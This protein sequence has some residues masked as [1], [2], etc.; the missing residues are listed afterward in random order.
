MSKLKILV[1][2]KAIVDLT[3]TPSFMVLS[4]RDLSYPIHFQ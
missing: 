4:I 2:I 3:M 1:I